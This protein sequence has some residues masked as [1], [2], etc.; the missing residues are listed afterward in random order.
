[1]T[2]RKRAQTAS[3][4]ARARYLYAHYGLTLHDYDLLLHR[5]GGR[6]LICHTPATKHRPLVVDHNHESGIVRG[7]LCGE[8]NTA[9]GLLGDDP[10]L[11]RRAAEYLDLTGDYAGTALA[12]PSEQ[13][14]QE[15]VQAQQQSA[16]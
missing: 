6:C 4:T 11:I 15:P 14:Q 13:V 16:A 7:L 10:A 12:R 2:T 9:I 8:C 5:Q 3:E 1:M